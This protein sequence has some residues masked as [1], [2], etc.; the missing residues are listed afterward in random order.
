M[1]VM[2]GNSS[3]P[4]GKSR[5]AA[6]QSESAVTYSRGSSKYDNRPAQCEALDFAEFVDRIAGD[7]AV[8]KGQQFF[9]A[10]F[11][12]GLHRDQ[13]KYPGVARWRQAHLARPRRFLPVDIDGMAE[14]AAFEEIKVFCSRFQG[15]AYT[16]ASHT[17]AAPRCHMVFELDRAT[18]R[19]E[20]I[21]LG[22]ALRLLVETELG[23]GRYLFDKSVFQAEQPCYMPPIDSEIFR[24]EG[25]PIEVDALLA[26]FPQTAAVPRAGRGG[27]AGGGDHENWLDDLLA[28]TNL[29][30][31]L[32]NL[33]ARWVAMGWTDEA[34]HAVVRTLL[35]RVAERR[36]AE[37]VEAMLRDGELDRMIEGARAKG[38][39]P[40][41][42]A[43]IL[44]DCEV[45]NPESS[46]EQIKAIID[47]AARSLEPVERDRIFRAVKDR[48]GTPMG[49]IRE[50]A[51]RAGDERNGGVPRDHLEIARS[52][53]DAIGGENL[54][55]TASSLWRYDTEAGC[56]AVLYPRAEK[57][58][59][60]SQIGRIPA[61]QGDVT[62]GL[63]DGVTDVL[64]TECYRPGHRWNVG[65]PDAVCVQNGELV[66]RGAEWELTP[67]QREHY[68]TASVPHVH[69]PE[70]K[71]P[72]FE[73]FLGE[74]FLG[75]PDAAEKVQL[76][77]ELMGYSLM[78]HTRYEKFVMLLGR[79]SNGKS[80][81]LSVLEALVGRGNVAAVQ[82][83]KFDNTNHRAHLLGKL[84]NLVTELAEGHMLP[85][86]PLKN[87]VSGEPIV[88]ELKFQH[89]FD[90]RSHATMWFATNH[91]PHS[92]DTSHAMMRRV[93]IVPFNRQFVAG[94]NADPLLTEKLLAE[95]PGILNLALRAY[96]QVVAQGCF[97]EPASCHEARER[98]M[99]DVNQVA[100]FVETECV[101][102]HQEADLLNL[103]NFYGLWAEDRGYRKTV[104]YNVFI[105]RLEQLGHVVIRGGPGKK[106]LVRGVDRHG[107]CK[108]KGG[109]TQPHKQT[110]GAT[111]PQRV[112]VVAG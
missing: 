56:W 69:D 90:M 100:M 48:T 14:P 108:K 84:V 55:S 74:V 9:C 60:Q 86:G 21:D 112:A 2:Q 70:A 50:T 85:D 11:E 93:L 65:P 7:R 64:I 103:F 41:T 68:R 49:V 8:E 54:I 62:K 106:D 10:A 109:Q 29:H 105:E 94:D 36:G 75:D 63:V 58:L 95:I 28:G 24:F 78:A 111:G 38:F 26:R 92:R 72:Q 57:H 6:T 87:L 39:A 107:A 110:R 99:A 71:A 82:P 59:V 20:G 27:V 81:F 66:L 77:L 18:D 76:L 51:K 30:D 4:I 31:S 17:A 15:M 35:E 83:A 101:P 80:V 42:Y 73:V 97:T 5:V 61:L 40:R 46:Q 47:D 1:N 19:G 52:I 104:G 96:A 25:S 43:E 23:E 33:T 88:A 89:P 44:A 45:L 53:R 79:G 37:R 13:K 67:H 16:T 98:W 34:I 22:Q 102:C 12:E 32:R 91:L 3:T